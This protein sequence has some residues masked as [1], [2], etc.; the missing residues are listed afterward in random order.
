MN[1]VMTSQEPMPVI[2]LIRLSS[3][4]QAREGK[5]GIARQR[6]Q[7]E[8]GARLHNL[9]I[10][11]TVE[12]ID[13]SGRHVAN[14]PQFQQIFRDLKT[15]AVQGVI[16]A[17]QSRLVRPQHY[18]DFKILD[19]FKNNRKLVYTPTDKLDPNTPAGWISLLVG[20][21]MSGN[22]LNLLRDRMRGGKEIKR[23]KGLHPMSTANLP[24]GV[25]FIR[26][27]NEHG[28]VVS[29]RWE[30]DGIDSERIR[31]AYELLFQGDS[32]PTIAAKI[33]GGWTDNGI[34]RA[35]RNLIWKGVRRYQWTAGT[36]EYLPKGSTKPRRRMVPREEVLEVP[37]D[38]EPIIS[39]ER[40]A[41][42]Q[43]IIEAKIHHHHRKTKKASRFLVS[44]LLICSCG[45]PYYL[46]CG[47]GRWP[48]D[49]YYCS[50]EPRSGARRLIRI[51][52]AST[53]AGTQSM[54][55]WSLW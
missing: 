41:K 2:G 4:E 54:K 17:E 5:E 47:S 39:P 12:A 15:S 46:R 38:L 30:H 19:H 29:E 42:A 9:Q 45:K 13:V 53:F 31:Q 18:E 3:E 28:K 25:K 32:Y 22:E 26:V 20:G 51:A 44:S 21:A 10:V 35:L 27:R 6:A 23:K 43:E 14:D 49:Q 8:M 34:R 7:I 1:S 36:E 24:R 37:I 55:R 50:S 52:A 48:R 16:V 40:W 11:R 33:G